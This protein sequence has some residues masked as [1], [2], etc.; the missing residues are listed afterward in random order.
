[1]KRFHRQQMWTYGQAYTGHY[2]TLFS[3]PK[4]TASHKKK[5]NLDQVIVKAVLSHANN[6]NLIASY[7][8]NK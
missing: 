3:K 8:T 6:K 4:H 7:I 1:M 5:K 2:F